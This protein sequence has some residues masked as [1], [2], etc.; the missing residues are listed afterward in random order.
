VESAIAV[1][2]LT[3]VMLLARHIGARLL[4]H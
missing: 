4:A 1:L 2:I 3:V